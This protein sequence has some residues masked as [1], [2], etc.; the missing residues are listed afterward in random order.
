MKRLFILALFLFSSL[1]YA[2]GIVFIG[3][4]ITKGT[5]YGGVTSSDTFAY[6]I[7][8]ANGYAP[9]AIY[10]KG[11]GSDTSAGVLARLQ[12]DAIS[13]APDVCVVMIGI[14]D[15][16]N[17]VSVVA[18]RQNIGAIFSQLIAAGIKP[19]GITSNLNRGSTATIA[20]YQP[21][22]EAFEAEAKAQGVK[23]LDLYREVADA[24]L[25]LSSTQFYA[26]Y[27][28]S[29]HLTKTGHQFVADF[30]AREKFGGVFL[31]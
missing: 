1:S 18:Y 13:K 19:V 2:S 11:I 20:G 15:W 4:S 28:D 8:V 26:L 10:N 9:A 23:V 3:D 30:A 14:N 24:Y 31:P 22:L 7:G 21:F 25:Y 6:K 5:D 29:I 16:A 17:G 27:V 12:S